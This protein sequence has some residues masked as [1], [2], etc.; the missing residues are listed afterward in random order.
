[1]NH[2]PDRRLATLLVIPTLLAACVSEPIID[3]KGVNMAQYRQDKAECTAY[4]EQ[5]KVGQKAAGHAAVG[6][7]VGAAIGAAIGNSGD[8]AS[9]AGVGATTGA[10]KGGDR[11]FAERERVVHACLR[12]RG[13]AVLN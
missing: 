5:V 13:Y 9:G 12:N 7:A 2:L 3:T 1:M 10:L 8:A 4:A 6:A 11:G